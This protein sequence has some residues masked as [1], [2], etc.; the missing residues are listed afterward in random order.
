MGKEATKEPTVLWLGL[1]STMA[2]SEPR[3]CYH[4][5]PRS[6]SPPRARQSLAPEKSGS[7]LRGIHHHFWGVTKSC[8]QVCLCSHH[9]RDV[10]RS[11][12]YL[13]ESSEDSHLT[14]G[15]STH[16]LSGLVDVQS[17]ATKI[18]FQQEIR[19]P[20]R[21]SLLQRGPAWDATGSDW[22]Q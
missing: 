5:R 1:L 21:P 7:I 9:R 8:A 6:N 22:N 10:A 2:G 15:T 3:I 12:L 17:L 18:V 4:L 19:R 20:S 14:S 16:F 13:Q 11:R